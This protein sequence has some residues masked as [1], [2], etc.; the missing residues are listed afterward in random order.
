[1]SERTGGTRTRIKEVALDLFTEQ[2]YE[3]TSLREIAER[4]GV[5]KAALYYHF[6]SKDEIVNGFVEDRLAHLDELLSWAREQPPSGQTRR[7]AL[8]R[9]ADGLHSGRHGRVMRFFEQNQPALKSMPAGK[10]IRER[11]FELIRVLAGPDASAADELRTGLA[12]FAMHTAWMGLINRELTEEQRR[13]AALEVANE[14]I[15][16]ADGGADRPPAAAMAS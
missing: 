7:E 15:D 9:Y 10:L 13:A 8:R 14:L 12:L 3:K 5:T 2:G 4:L 6:K 11:M 1:M 16:R